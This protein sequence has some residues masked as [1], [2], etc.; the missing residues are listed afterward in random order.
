MDCE[1]RKQILEK[2]RELIRI[3]DELT[4]YYKLAYLVM[5]YLLELEEELRKR[6]VD[7]CLDPY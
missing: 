3:V 6:Y 1:E 7:S 5:Y 2:I 4:G